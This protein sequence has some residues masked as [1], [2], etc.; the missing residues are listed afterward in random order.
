MNHPSFHAHSLR[1]MNLTAAFLTSSPPAKC[2]LIIHDNDINISFLILSFSLKNDAIKFL[3]FSK[4]EDFNS[5]S[6]IYKFIQ[7]LLSL[8]TILL[9]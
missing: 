8:P 4:A 2:K 6:C 9:Y 1:K 7:L 3:L 5:K